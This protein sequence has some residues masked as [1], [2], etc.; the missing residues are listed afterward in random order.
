MASVWVFSI[1]GSDESDIHGHLLR[2]AIKREATKCGLHGSVRNIKFEPKIEVKMV[3]SDISQAQGFIE[4]LKQLPCLNGFMFEPIY[5]QHGE[6]K[7]KYYDFKVIREDE[8]TEMVWALQGAGEEFAKSAKTNL[9]ILNEIKMRDEREAQSRLSSL[10]M[11]IKFMRSIVADQIEGLKREGVFHSPIEARNL[12]L[13]EA[14]VHPPY[15]D[16]EFI[17]ATNDIYY[18]LEDVEK[19]SKKFTMDKVAKEEKIKKL[20]TYQKNIDAYIQR[21]SD[22]LAMHRGR[23]DEL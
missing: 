12:C 5:E 8:L 6:I 18:I 7:E 4:K 13:R 19:T 16:D 3:A 15:K 11:E 20:E 21:I 14:M 1:A 23:F 2:L 17:Y 9:E 10:L 22:I